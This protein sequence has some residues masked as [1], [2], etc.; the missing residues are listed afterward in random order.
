[1][2][3][4]FFSS[5]SVMKALLGSHCLGCIFNAELNFLVERSLHFVASCVCM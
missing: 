4:S 2:I 3:V 1:M 5:L